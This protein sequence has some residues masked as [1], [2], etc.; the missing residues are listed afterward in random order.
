MELSNCLA[1]VATIGQKPSS[2]LS[3]FECIRCRKRSDIACQFPNRLRR[4]DPPLAEQ[5]WYR[6]PRR[7]LNNATFRGSF[8]T[9]RT[10]FCARRLP[11]LPSTMFELS[12]ATWNKKFR[13]AR[14][15]PAPISA[16]IAPLIAVRQGARKLAY[17]T[18]SRRSSL[19]VSRGVGRETL[20]SLRNFRALEGKTAPHY[21]REALR[22]RPS[23]PNVHAWTSQN[24]SICQ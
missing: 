11:P 24:A 22:R 9:I 10:D 6:A 12:R 3:S 7:R 2:R 21:L 18:I 23:A 17:W 13:A 20:A 19:P 14:M 16:A 4:S 5:T 1:L 8:R 15:P